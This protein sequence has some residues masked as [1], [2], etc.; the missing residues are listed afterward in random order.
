MARATTISRDGFNKL[1]EELEYL[2]TVRRK[3]VAERLKEARSY[4]DL[5]ENAEYDEAK[6]E[7][8]MLEAQIADL[9]VVIANAVIVDDDSL[10]LDE[11]GVGS[12]VKLKDFDMDEILT[13]QIVGSTESDPDN[14]KI[15]DESPIGKACL[16]KKIGDIF[17]VEVPAGTLKFE[18]LGID[19]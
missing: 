9:E 7:Q 19:R 16:K 11:V 13:Y 10:S 12:I 4:G 17:E 6:N 3:E 8:G 15:S 18:I 1:Q 14:D 5:S 2:V